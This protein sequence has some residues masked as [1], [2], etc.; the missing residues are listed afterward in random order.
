MENIGF[1]IV[2]AGILLFALFSRK[3]EGSLLT[4]PMIF[5]VFGWAVGS[6]AGDLLPLSI[7]HGAMHTLA[8]ITLILV[9]FSDAAQANLRLLLKDHTL[10]SRMLLI[11]MPL[12]ILLGAAVAAW[13]SPAAPLALAFLTATILTPTDAALGQAIVSSPKVPVRIRQAINVESGLN[14]GIALPIVM[15]CAILTSAAYGTTGAHQP[16]NLWLFTLL[17]I[18]LGPLVGMGVGY[19]GAKLVDRASAQKSM[20]VAFQGIAF[21][22]LAATAYLLAETVGGNGFIATFVAGL[23]FGS[24]LKE[25]SESLFEFME[26]EGQLLTMITFL[27]FGA[28]MVPL[29]LEHATWKTIVLA[30]LYL[31]VIRMLPIFLSLY[32]TGLKAPDKLLLGWF[33]PRGLASILFALLILNRF[34]IPGSDE[35]LACIVL[36]VILSIFAHGFSATPLVNAYALY[37]SERDAKEAGEQGKPA[38]VTVNRN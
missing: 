23:L 20:S 11:G 31:T 34:P 2:A 18:T 17:Q 9:L 19:A 12:T 27:I 7:G 37:I 8:E 33:G 22:S 13:V 4:L 3:L 26:T 24:T 21:L 35:L 32:G 38:P 25:H 10:P 29:G 28:V 14:D 30:V 6:G 36:T 1:L 15:I 16:D 5:T